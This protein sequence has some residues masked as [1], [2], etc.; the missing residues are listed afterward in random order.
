LTKSPNFPTAL[1]AELQLVDQLFRARPD[2]ERSLAE[3]DRR[4]TCRF[5]YGDFAIRG[6]TNVLLA[7]NLR[8]AARVEV[9]RAR[10][11]V[12]KKD[13]EGAIRLLLR[14]SRL[15]RKGKQQP[16]DI[17]Y[18]VGIAVQGV[19]FQEINT[20][21]QGCRLP[22]AVHAAI[23]VELAA[24]EGDRDLWASKALV[25]RIASTQ[26][27]F[28][29]MLGSRPSA[30]QVLA[31]N[32]RIFAY[33]ALTET[34]GFTGRSYAETSG[35][36]RKQREHFESPTGRVLH[37]GANAVMMN[38]EMSY[39]ASMRILARAR[40]LRVINA[41]LRSGGAPSSIETL[42]LPKSAILDPYTDSPLKMV[43]KPSGLLVYSIGQNLIDDGGNIAKHLD[44]GY[45]T[46]K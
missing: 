33:D 42:G 2:Y 5:E 3:A 23:D 26:K 13:R 28:E 45:S 7:D 16:S 6:R 40:S 34:A 19:V 25:L 14:V 12:G 43:V 20:V 37:S 22:A 9:C 36:I 11:L 44:I 10:L 41:V 31:Y 17:D 38:V 32:D 18:L 29:V 1:P 24:M 30:L 8:A 35:L 39:S 27:E 46:E 4:P 15:A 21:F